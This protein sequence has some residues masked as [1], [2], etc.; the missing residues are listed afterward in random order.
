MAAAPLLRRHGPGEPVSRRSYDWPASELRIGGTAGLPTDLPPATFRSQ[1]QCQTT[2]A[3]ILGPCHTSDVPIRRDVTEGVAGLPLHLALRLVDARDCR[4]IEGADVE[5]W[6]A[7]ARGIY[8]G[9]AA[10]MCNPDDRKV[11]EA[12]FLRG[13]R[14][15]DGDGVVDF[16]TVYPGWYRGRA[17][18]IHFR[19]L[20]AGR[21]LLVT[22][23][24]FDDS[25]SDLI[26]AGHGEYGGR[27]ARDT[28]NGG[29]GVF[30]AGEASQFIFDVRKLDGGILQASYTIGVAGLASA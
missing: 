7:D 30:S 19:I 29:D 12:A 20:I 27:P 21:E 5:I 15:S 14:I 4:P 16:L 9:R 11:R 18:H 2:L 26:Y 3:K 10:G 23:L 6:H 8:S 28:L 25:L 24:L 13:R 22:Q 17:V 1:P